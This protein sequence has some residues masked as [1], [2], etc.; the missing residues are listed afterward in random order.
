MEDVAR[1]VCIRFHEDYLVVER[2][3]G[4]RDFVDFA[5]HGRQEDN[6]MDA[7]LKHVSVSGAFVECFRE[8]NNTVD[9]L[10]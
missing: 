6:S 9:L 2:Y 3:T 10:K 4:V 7:G 8:I 5:R 1:S